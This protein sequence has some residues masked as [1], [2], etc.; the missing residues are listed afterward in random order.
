M[1][2]AR[3]AYDLLR[4]YVNRE[5]DR[6]RQSDL[7]D[8]VRELDDSLRGPRLP[9]A[10]PTEPAPRREDGPPSLDEKTLA[11]SILAV[12]D[13]ATF[14]QVRQAFE[15]LNKRSN[16]ANFPPG[17]QEAETAARIQT[18]IHWA[19]RVLTDGTPE[20]QKRFKSLELD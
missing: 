18:R 13:G 17:S 19:Y 20:S 2:D 14:E 16:P 1:S 7:A 3:R 5:W 9:D 8:A 6:I 10:P 15:K 12:E 11:R 4:G